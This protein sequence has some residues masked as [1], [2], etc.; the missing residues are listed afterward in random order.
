MTKDVLLYDFPASICSQMARLALAEKGV[1]YRRRIVDIMDRAEQF[2]PW[3]TALNPQAVVPTLAI[4]KE[5]VT[6]TKAIVRRIDADFDGPPLTPA[7]PDQ[8]AAMNE[9]MDAI[10]DLHYGVLLYAGRLDEDRK[11]DTV[12]ARG[13]FLRAMRDDHRELADALNARIEGNARLR[14]ILADPA[15]VGRHVGEAREL[16]ERL[17]GALAESAFVAGDA[18]SLADTFATAALARFCIHGFNVWWADGKMP[19][20]AGYYARMKDRPSFAEAGVVD[21]G[22]E[23]DL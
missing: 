16:A 8:V 9:T 13:K 1:T 17:N 2:E 18:Y 3:Y 10:M 7:D 4:G 21:T 20:L 11:S 23:R 19:H 15:E 6:D 5:I 12:E 14:R 22:S